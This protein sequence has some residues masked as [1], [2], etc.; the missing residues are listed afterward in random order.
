MEKVNYEEDLAKP[1]PIEQGVW[2]KSYPS[3][4][5]PLG[6]DSMLF[7]PV[8]HITEHALPKKA[9]TMDWLLSAM[10]VDLKKLDVTFSRVPNSLWATLA[11]DTVQFTAT[12]P[13]TPFLLNTHTHTHT[14]TN[15]K[16]N[17]AFRES[18]GISP[19]KSI[20]LT[21]LKPLTVWITTNCGKFLKR[22]EYQ[23]TLLVS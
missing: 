3:A 10:E 21:M 15:N 6:Q 11:L 1:Q 19:Q 23:S 14:H 5:S 7:I 18:K 2:N 9:K 20:S 22:Q 16:K 12:Q 17:P 13:R 8:S 4:L